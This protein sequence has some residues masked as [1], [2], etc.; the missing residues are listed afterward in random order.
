M[1][2]QVFK[3]DVEI[4]GKKYTKGQVVPDVDRDLLNRW[5][6]AR[7][8]EDHPDCIPSAMFCLIFMIAATKSV[9]KG[10]G[11]PKKV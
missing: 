1:R 7:F 2:L 4:N 8:V 11:R 3:Q 6:R 9:K 10:P 5:R